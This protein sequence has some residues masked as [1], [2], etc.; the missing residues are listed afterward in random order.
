MASGLK[1]WLGGNVG[2]FNIAGRWLVPVSI[3]ISGC[4]GRP[5][6]RGGGDM[7]LLSTVK[8]FHLHLK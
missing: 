6:G 1:E 3:Y 5:V 8:I 7:A 4:L 2:Y